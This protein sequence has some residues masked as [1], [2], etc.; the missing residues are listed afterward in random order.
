MRG[1][2]RCG[3]RTATTNWS[4]VFKSWGAPN[5][6][7]HGCG[8]EFF[9]H[10]HKVLLPTTAFIQLRSLLGDYQNRNGLMFAGGWT[11]WFDTQEAALMSAMNVAEMLQ[12]SGVSK[13]SPKPASSYDSSVIPAQVK[14]WIEMTLENAP[15]PYQSRLVQ[16]AGELG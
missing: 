7:S 5:L 8:S 13:P 1:L 4:P 16:L 3:R 11:T 6:E 14:S 15:P 2:D 10:V 12:S 9:S